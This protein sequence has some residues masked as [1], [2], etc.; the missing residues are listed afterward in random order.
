MRIH[1]ILFVSTQRGWITFM[2]ATTH[3]FTDEC[4]MASGSSSWRGIAYIRAKRAVREYIKLHGAK[5]GE[6]AAMGWTE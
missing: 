6:R 5:P 2:Y 3:Q 1:A 4:D